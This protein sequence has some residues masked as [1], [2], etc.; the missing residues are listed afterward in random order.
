MKIAHS[1]LSRR[2]KPEFEESFALVQRSAALA[3]EAAKS[4]ERTLT[5]ERLKALLEFYALLDSAVE[6]LLAMSPDQLK[7][8]LQ[9]MGQLAKE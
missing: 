9:L 4:S 3:K 7:Q 5:V 6:S 2:H 1:V 8:A